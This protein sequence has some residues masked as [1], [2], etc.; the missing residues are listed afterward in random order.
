MKNNKI[1]FGIIC[2]VALIMVNVVVFTT[3]KDF[4]TARCINIGFL[5]LS[6]IIALFF[7]I[8]FG[9]KDYK[10]MNYS[11]LPIVALYFLLTF[12]ISTIFIICN[13]KNITVTIVTQII[14]LGLFVIAM[15]SNT[16]ANN[17]SENSLE[18]DKTNYNKVS[19]MTTRLNTLL[20]NISDREVYKKVEKAY[21]DVKSTK[22]NISEDT[23]QI[24]S[25]ILQAIAILE[26]NI[27]NN[28]YNV[29]DEQI[30][31]IHSLII[32]RNQMK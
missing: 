5:N 2:A 22:I 6:V 19:D 28:V 12:I 24:D 7:T 17:S 1:L 32:T 21:D 14:L 20:K 4:N 15:A 10:F 30:N 27:Q 16:M 9:K 13:L 26:N 8:M 31:K 25:E 18:K 11:R 29:I 23:S 3:V